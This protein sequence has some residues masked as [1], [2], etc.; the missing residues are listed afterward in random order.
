[1]RDTEGVVAIQRLNKEIQDY[2]NRTM[3]KY[4]WILSTVRLALNAE[5]TDPAIRL[6]EQVAKE[7][8]A[9]R[10]N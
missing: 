4:F 2:E 10:Y 6:P 7:Y 9:G 8:M 3:F 5:E 1:L